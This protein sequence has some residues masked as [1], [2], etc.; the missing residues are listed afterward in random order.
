MLTRVK[1]KQIYK[2][3][4][5]LAERYAVLLQSWFLPVQVSLRCVCR[6][7]PGGGTL[8]SGGKSGVNAEDTQVLCSVATTGVAH[9]R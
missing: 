1:I 2:Y 4:D 6:Y 5:F 7:N 9:K 3:T 8:A